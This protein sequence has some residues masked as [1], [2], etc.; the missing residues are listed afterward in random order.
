MRILSS[1]MVVLGSAAMVFAQG[2]AST[3]RWPAQP[4]PEVDRLFQNTDGWIGGDGA[5]SVAL[6]AERTLWLFSDTWVGKVQGGKRTNASLV[7]NTVAI[8]EGRGPQAR[9]RFIVRTAND[10]K[11]AALIT[12]A[13]GQGWFWLFAGLRVDDKLYLFLAQFEKSGGGAFGFRQIGQWLGIVS[14]PEAEPTAWKIEQ[15]RL[16]FAE[17]SRQRQRSFGAA[18]LQ[19]GDQVYIYGTDEDD[20]QALHDR[21]LTLARVPA[22]AIGDFAAWRFFHDGRWVADARLADHLADGMATEG[23]VHYD[24]KAN[25]YV[26]VYSERWL[27]PRI[28][29]RTA[30]APMGPWSPSQVLYECPEPAHDKRLFSY[31]AKAHPEISREGE[32]LISYVTNSSD[33]WHVAR[34][35]S[36]YWPRFVRVPTSAFR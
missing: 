1:L 18:M 33:F 31:A 24:A 4:A 21:Y 19:K 3:R 22:A 30:A 14:N 13:D 34:D 7:N 9:V 16:P 27:S 36:L 10:G 32:L 17:F 29:A 5:Y 8:Q 12:P 25:H 23:S 15:R 35:A 20:S 2:E 28:L 26:L 11:P 6:S